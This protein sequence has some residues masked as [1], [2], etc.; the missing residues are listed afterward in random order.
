MELWLYVRAGLGWKCSL[1]RR[2]KNSTQSIV[3][4]IRATIARSTKRKRIAPT[5]RLID[6]LLRSTITIDSNPIRILTSHFRRWQRHNGQISR[7]SSTPY[8]RPDASG[9]PFDGFDDLRIYVFLF[10]GS[11]ASAAGSTAVRVRALYTA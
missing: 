4:L 3:S 5:D 6:P 7:P 9:I 2:E 8:D 10:C 1:A 11:R